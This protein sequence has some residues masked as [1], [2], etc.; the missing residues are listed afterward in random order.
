[1]AAFGRAAE[2]AAASG[3]AAVEIHGGHGY[4]IQQFLAA[5]SNKR[6]DRFGGATVAERS[7]FGCEV[8]EAVRERP[9]S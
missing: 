4:L 3:F 9:R 7:R 5:E 8:I 6:T 1:M 2:R